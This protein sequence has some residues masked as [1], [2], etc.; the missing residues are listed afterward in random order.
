MRTL[1]RFLNFIA[2]LVVT[3]VI[4]WHEVDNASFSQEWSK[5]IA[6]K[7][8]YALLFVSGIMVLLNL[9]TIFHSLKQMHKRKRA[10]E[11]ENDSGVNSISID[12]VQKRLSEMLNATTDIIHPRLYLE[13]GSKNKPIRCNVEFGLKCTRNI[14]G[15]TDEI[16]SQITS[17]FNN[18]IPNGPGII[19]KA[20]IIEIENDGEAIKP[21][22]DTVFSGPIYPNDEEDTD[23][24]GMS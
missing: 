4:Y 19:V 5:F 3:A 1:V 8:V 23:T 7:G 24:K 9:Y 14:T 22:R 10:I 17:V 11:I 18:M 20:S 13:L 2:V 21:E 12:A 6:G 15:R 16:K